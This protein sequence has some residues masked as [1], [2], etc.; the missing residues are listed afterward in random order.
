MPAIAALVLKNNAEANVTFAPS[1]LTNGLATFLT[2]DSVFDAKRKLTTS[3]QLP[4]PG[5]SVSRIK[6]KVTVPIMD[7]V[8]ATKKVAEMIINVDAVLPKSSSVAQR[9]DAR[10]FTRDLLA[11]ADIT[12]MFTDLESYY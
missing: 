4:K 10:N 12:K 2:N 7:A 5:S 8:D 6:F 9:L 11:H 1:G 3:V